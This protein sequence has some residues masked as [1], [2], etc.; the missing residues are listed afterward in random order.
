MGRT[1]FTMG[2]G[3]GEPWAGMPVG[4]PVYHMTRAEADRDRGFLKRLPV[5]PGIAVQYPYMIKVEGEG[6][7]VVKADGT[8]SYYSYR[9]GR[10][11]PPQI[12]ENATAW[13]RTLGL[14]IA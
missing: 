11:E 3:N 6:E 14:R 7:Y 4:I 12:V 1:M 9:D 2:F 8:A 13:R 10:W 5:P